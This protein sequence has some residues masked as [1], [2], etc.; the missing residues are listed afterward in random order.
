MALTAAACRAARALLKWSMRDLAQAS[1]VS[2]PTLLKIERGDAVSAEVARK[3][4]TAFMAHH[5]TLRVGRGEGAKLQPGAGAP[6]DDRATL[7]RSLP[8]VTTKGP[9]AD[10]TYRV[11]FEVPAR[12]RPPGW[13][14][15][16]PLPIQA[17][18]RGDLTDPREVASIRKD[19]KALHERL[20]SARR[21][22]GEGSRP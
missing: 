12:L 19:A 21:G 16:T 10:G 15:T 8:M 6:L 3:V 11:L 14:P 2:L 17:P 5:V 7:V 22:G 4:E 13:L 9:R 20:K 18:R 1:G